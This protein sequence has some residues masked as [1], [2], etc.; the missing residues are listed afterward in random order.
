MT[1]VPALLVA[2]AYV[3]MHLGKLHA[4][5]QALVYVLA[6]GPFLVLGIVVYVVR[7]RDLAEDEDKRP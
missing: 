7:R 1:S 5:E 2:A 4:W 3:A 6:F